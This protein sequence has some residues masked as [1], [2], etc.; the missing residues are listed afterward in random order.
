MKL[1]TTINTRSHSNI[2]SREKFITTNAHQ[3]DMPTK[4]KNKDWLKMHTKIYSLDTIITL[5]GPWAY[6]SNPFSG[7]RQ[8]PDPQLVLM[9]CMLH[10]EQRRLHLLHQQL[11]PDQEQ[12]QL[13][14]L[15]VRIIDWQ[16]CREKTKRGCGGTRL[17]SN[18]PMNNHGLS[19]EKS[20]WDFSDI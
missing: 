1:S 8:G 13:R 15:D 12:H 18:N 14:Q 17:S 7:V 16:A 6:H 20:L 2:K 11:R 3:H 5:G 19:L 10:Q 4:A 9:G